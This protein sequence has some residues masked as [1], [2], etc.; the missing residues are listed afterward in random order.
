MSISVTDVKSLR[1]R[2]GAGMMDCKKALVECE[3]ELEKAI[4]WLRT[5]GL[6]KAAKR[7]GRSTAQGVIHSYIHTG[8]KIGVLL[9]L[10]CE[11]DFVARTDDFIELAKQLAI[12]IAASNPLFISKEDVDPKVL[13]HERDIARAQAIE[14]GKPE[15][16]IDKIADGRVDKWTKEVCLLDQPF[17][18]DPDKTVGD[19]LAEAFSKIGEAMSIRRFVRWQVGEQL[20]E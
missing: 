14:D 3:G 1:E 5:K 6:A 19:L 11:S 2:T 18:K 10:N 15:K 9:E 12:H 17:V 20:P 7:A 8:G 13:A 16:I 4:D